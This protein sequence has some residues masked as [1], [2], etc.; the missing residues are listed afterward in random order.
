MIQA[1]T[2]RGSLHSIRTKQQGK[3]MHP[4]HLEAGN[5]YCQVFCAAG[6]AD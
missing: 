2:E 4:S 1:T 3:L 6:A 5:S